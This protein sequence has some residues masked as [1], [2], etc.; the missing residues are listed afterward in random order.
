M[1]AADKLQEMAVF[2]PPAPYLWKLD[3]KDRPKVLLR[4]TH[5]R[6]VRAALA[7]GYIVRLYQSLKETDQAAIWQSKADALLKT[8]NTIKNKK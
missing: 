1:Q 5:Q 3:E 7:V 2:S 4:E 8:E 6:R